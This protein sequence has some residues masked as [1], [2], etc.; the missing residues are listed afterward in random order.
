MAKKW[1]WYY[2]IVILC[3]FSA[4]TTY[5]GNPQNQEFTTLKPKI[6]TVATYFTNPPFEF[7]NNDQQEGFE[8]DLISEIAKRLNLQVE[9]KN[10]RWESIIQELTENRYDLIMGAITITP[11]RQR[12]IT[13]SEPYMTTT[14][15]IVINAEATP[16]IKKI[17]D[18]N[19]Q[20]MGVQA[21]TTDLEIAQQMKDQGNLRKIKIYPFSDFDS[22]I[23]DLL[24]GSIG[25]VIKVFPVASYYV[26]QHPDLKILASVP[27]DPQ[28]LGFG[29][30]SANKG[31]INAVNKVQA[32]MKADGT[33]KKIYE[34]WF[35]D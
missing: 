25:A 26:P 33:Y 9:L 19:D 6:L 28:S 23:N 22:A 34:R 5:S 21:A 11:T 32:E 27:N 13:F 29:I 12:L 7:I 14:L 1:I 18:L 30:N 35:G 3:S 2:I 16:K 17:A 10:T 4:I 24:A 31:L 15:S 20:T 8:V